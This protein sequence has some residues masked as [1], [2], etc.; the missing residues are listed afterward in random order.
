MGM[1]HINERPAPLIARNQIDEPPVESS[2][3]VYD[4]PE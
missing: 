2:R 1:Y 4:G 3:V